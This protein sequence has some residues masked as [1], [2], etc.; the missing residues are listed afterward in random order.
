L[1]VWVVECLLK[2]ESYYPPRNGGALV[3]RKLIL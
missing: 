2:E 3:C 1:G